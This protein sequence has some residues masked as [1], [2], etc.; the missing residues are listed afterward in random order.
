MMIAMPNSS[1]SVTAYVALGAN[2][3]DRAAAIYSAVARLSRSDGVRLGALSS[4]IETPPVGGPQGSP[5]FLNA[6]ARIET[7]LAPHPL[8]HLLLQ[9]E[10]DLGRVRRTK[11][12]PRPIDIDLLLYGDRILSSESLII[13]HPLMHRRRFVLEPLAQIAPDA[14]HPMLQMSVAGLLDGAEEPES[15]TA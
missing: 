1:Q 15:P 4:L 5:M 3:G 13:P 9:I 14:V 12:E 11:W 2:L 7:T 8:M 6:A 10:R